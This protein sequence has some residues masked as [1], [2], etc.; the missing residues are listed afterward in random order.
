ML[1]FPASISFAL[2]RIHIK[3]SFFVVWVCKSSHV[4]LFAEKSNILHRT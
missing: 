4:L 2:Y 3:Y 1:N